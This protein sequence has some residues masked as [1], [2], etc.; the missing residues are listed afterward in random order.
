MATTAGPLAALQ[1]LHVEVPR[2]D[3][4][5]DELLLE[6]LQSLRSE[7]LR[8]ADKTE[9]RLDSMARRAEDVEVR[10]RTATA[11]LE[12]LSQYQF[13]EHTVDG[14]SS[15]DESEGGC[16]QGESGVSGSGAG[17]AMETDYDVIQRALDIGRRFVEAP[18]PQTIWGPLPPVVG[19]PEFWAASQCTAS[20]TGSADAIDSE[21]AAGVG[22]VSEAANAGEPPTQRAG[23]PDDAETCNEELH[24]SLSDGLATNVSSW[25]Q[26]P[27]PVVCQ[28]ADPFGT[29]SEADSEIPSLPPTKPQATMIADIR[30]A[31]ARR[32]GI[33]SG[34]WLPD[35]DDTPGGPEG[36]FPG[37]LGQPPKFPSPSRKAS[38]VGSSLFFGNAS[39][40]DEV[41]TT[42]AVA[43][44]PLQATRDP[45]GSLFGE[46]E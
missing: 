14:E 3:A 26:P 36:T 40:Y 10:L 45:L 24:N 42:V 4:A 15:E 1:A 6:A 17:E 19:T 39:E 37:P 11:K 20:V 34:P 2:W 12:I 41:V 7:M 13:V 9:R 18:P 5:Q 35:I 32:A 38:G 27:H 31:V 46:D 21:P 33:D 29:H 23:S 25:T 30:E 22:P 43:Q 16:E 28:P 44:T 8:R